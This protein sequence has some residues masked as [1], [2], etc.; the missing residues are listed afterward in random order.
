MA[1]A[2]LACLVLGG[3]MLARLSGIEIAPALSP[4]KSAAEIVRRCGTFEGSNWFAM[5]KSGRNWAVSSNLESCGAAL[6]LAS[7]I[8]GKDLVSIANVGEF[9]C[10]A[11]KLIGGRV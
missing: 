6:G 8:A 7:N 5:G 3:P 10:T 2:S 11:S 4:A 9:R 1:V